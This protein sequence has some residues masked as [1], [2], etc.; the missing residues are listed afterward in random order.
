MKLTTMSD[1][2][3]AVGVSVM[4]VSKV[5]NNKPNV[6]E[7]TRQK[8]LN[9]AH[10]LGYKP[11]LI[12][13]S[14][15]LN[16]TKTIGLVISDSSFSFFPSVIKGIE[17][18]A[19]RNGYS[20]LLCNTNG[21]HQTEKEKID[22]LMNKR[23]DGIILAAST[24]I[25]PEDTGYLAS[26]GVPFIYAIRIPMDPSAD[27]VANDNYNGASM[28]IDYLIRTGSR[29][30]H[31][32]NMKSV[33]TSSLDRL[34]GYRKTLEKN[35]IAYDEEII[36]AIDHTVDAGYSLTKRL[37]S[38][39]KDMKA[40]FC[41]CDVIAIGVME[42]ILEMGYK[43]PDDIRVASYDDIDFAQYLQV[44]LTTVRQPKYSIGIKSMETLIN[45]INNPGMEPQIVMLESEL[46][47]R[48]ST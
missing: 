12:A 30:I 25:S 36:Y 24:F 47:I 34:E 14:M 39:G 19:V 11:N 26:L 13:R 32:I 35:N 7:T 28:M 48:K 3:K 33:S 40:I 42:A 10:K 29:N 6:R 2:A 17:D 21:D 31:F 16:Q 4:T 27:C 41:G 8:V 23:V 46:V 18:C 38:Y 43:I 15:R 5:L 9:A 22:L 45:R 20:I 44:P 1:I 37:L